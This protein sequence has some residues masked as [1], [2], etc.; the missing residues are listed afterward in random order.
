MDK[1]YGFIY[2]DMNDK[3][4]GDLH[5]LKRIPFI[6]I[7]KLLPATDMILIKMKRG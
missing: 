5:R 2:G 1:R 3:G 6:G 4:E 7:K